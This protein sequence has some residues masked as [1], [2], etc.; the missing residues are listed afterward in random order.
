MTMT[1]DISHPKFESGSRIRLTKV[2]YA[3]LFLLVTSGLFFVLSMEY[4]IHLVSTK[5]FRLAETIV[6]YFALGQPLFFFAQLSIILFFLRPAAQISDY[7]AVRRPDRSVFRN[8]WL[9]L[10]AGVTALVATLPSS[11][12]HREPSGMVMFLLDHLSIGAALGFVLLLVVLLPFAQAIFFNGILLRQLLESISPISALIVSTLVLM[13][14][15]PGLNSWPAF[16]LIAGAS[17][18]LATGIVFWRT[19]SVLACAIANASFTAG[20]IVLQ[21]WRMP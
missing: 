1:A 11:I 5:R 10:L 4:S 20:A 3:T 16:Y 7:L 9:G 19:K 17:L 21:L 6:E 2:V 15:W 18:G 14:S 13:L 12:G 8:I